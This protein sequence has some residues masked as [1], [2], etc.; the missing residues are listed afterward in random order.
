MSVLTKERLR[1]WCRQSTEL[2]VSKVPY[3]PEQVPTIKLNS[4]I[5]IRKKNGFENNTIMLRGVVIR[6]YEYENKQGQKK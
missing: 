3:C 2:I 5:L 1:Y 4:R 6:V